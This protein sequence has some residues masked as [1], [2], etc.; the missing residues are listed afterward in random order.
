MIFQVFSEIPKIFFRNLQSFQEFSRT[1]NPLEIFIKFPPKSHNFPHKRKYQS[2]FPRSNQNAPKIIHQITQKNR[3]KAPNDGL[4]PVTL[5][6]FNSC[7]FFLV[8]LQ[9][10][11]MQFNQRNL[12]KILDSID[13]QFNCNLQKADLF[14]ALFIAFGENNGIAKKITIKHN[15]KLN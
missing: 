12:Q 4:I 5:I 6:R 2:S 13:G 7:H 1:S 8:C 15:L 9:C 10:F 11:S 14:V 3:L